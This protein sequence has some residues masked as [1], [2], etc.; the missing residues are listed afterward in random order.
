MEVPDADGSL[1]VLAAQA[2][3]DH[4]EVVLASGTV[5]RDPADAVAALRVDPPGVDVGVDAHDRHAAWLATAAGR[6]AER[7]RSR[8]THGPARSSA[9]PPAVR[10]GR[11]RLEVVSAAR[12]STVRRRREE[13]GK[14]T[15]P[16]RAAAARTQR[17]RH[18]PD[19]R[20]SAPACTRSY[21]CQERDPGVGRDLLCSCALFWSFVAV[22]QRR[23][24]VSPAAVSG[25]DRRGADV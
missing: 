13:F 21:A 8:L 15:G 16:P 23:T 24:R 5:Q 11:R 20:V 22:V 18:L 2:T 17:H 9:S 6:H 7:E 10:R 3:D 19:R 14:T 25:L 1:A 4:A 12:V